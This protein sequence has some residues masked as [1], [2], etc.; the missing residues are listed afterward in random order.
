MLSC[1]LKKIQ[2]VVKNNVK[3][4]YKL[5]LIFEYILFE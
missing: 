2:N 5:Q 3:Y 1:L 4:Y